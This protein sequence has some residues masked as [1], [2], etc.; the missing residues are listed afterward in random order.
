M[1]NTFALIIALLAVLA[2]SCSQDELLEKRRLSYIDDTEFFASFD[3]DSILSRTYI[4]ED[5]ETSKLYLRWTKADEITIFR[6]N[7]LNQRYQY[8][9]ETGDNSAGFRQIASDDFVSYN[10]LDNPTN[11]AVYPYNENTRITEKGVL[12]VALPANQKYA[13]KSFGL[14]ANTMVAVTQHTGDVNLLFKNVCGYFKFKFYGED[15]TIRSVTL[16]GNNEENLAGNANVTSGYGSLPAMTMVSDTTKTLTLDCGEAGI[17]VG[18]TKET[19]TEFWFVVPPTQFTK[20]FTITVTDTDGGKFTKTTEKVFEIKRNIVKPISA[21]EVE[22]V[23]DYSAMTVPDD[24]I[25]YIPTTKEGIKTNLDTS[26]KCNVNIVSHTY[27]NGKAIIKFDGPLLEIGSNN[28]GSYLA[29]GYVKEL[30]LPNC[31]ERI[32]YRALFG[33]WLKFDEYINY[34]N[35]DP[36]RRSITEFK[37]PDNL[38]EVDTNLF[39]ESRITK[40]IGK[41]VS[42][43]GRSLVVDGELIG[44]AAW[45]LEEYSVPENVSTING[46]IMEYSTVKKLVVPENVKT[47]RSG[48]INYCPYLKELYLPDELY[49]DEGGIDNCPALEE[50]HLPSNLTLARGYHFLYCDNIKNIYGENKYVTADNKCIIYPNYAYGL[51]YILMAAKNGLEEYSIPEGIGGLESYSFSNATSLRKLYF[52]ASLNRIGGD[53]FDGTY[54]VEEISGPNVRDDKRSLVVDGNLLYVAGGGLTTYTTPTDVTSIRTRSLS[55]MQEL[56]ELVIT[57]NVERFSDSYP[58]LFNHC[59]KL[60]TITISANIQHLGYDPFDCD[61]TDTPSLKTVYC[62]AYIPPKIKWNSF[63]VNTDFEDLTIYVPQETLS[64]YESSEDW[65]RLREYI[66]GYNYTDL[67][68]PDYYISTDYSQD[69][70]VTTLQTA[71]KGNGIDIVLMGDGYSDRQIADGTYD[72]TMNTAMEKF[73]SEE[74]YKNYRDHFNVYSVKAVSATEGY[75]CNNTA[76]SGYFGSGTRV[77]GDDKRVFTYAQKAI[78]E[79]R[80]D[81]ALI[82]VMMNST[83]YAGTCY[84]YHPSVTEGYGNGVSVSYFPVGEDENALAQVLHH[85]AGGHGFAKLADEYAY[86]S[87]GAIP[88]TEVTT[89]KEEQT[90]W[91]WWKNVDFTSDPSATRWSHFINDTRYANDGLGAYEGGLTYWT[92][93][94]RPT[95]NSIMRHNTGGFNAPS[96]EAIYYRIHKLAYGD[97]WQYDYEEFVKYDAINRKAAASSYNPYRQT[98]YKPLHAPVVIRKSWKDAQ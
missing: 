37:V 28:G 98:N 10:D 39:K 35:E 19:A 50:L 58:Y 48:A 79:E 85:E 6:G 73:F 77:G 30:Y 52:P 66:K 65:V 90:N 83:R 68:E 71:T 24:E 92:G 53:A 95:E 59:P 46:G 34:N 13:E 94:W 78:D 29:E 82:V 2:S 15:L 93:V 40:L 21:I 1:R 96:R 45:G 76:F 80:M 8:K 9:G 63:S 86:E 60:E 72:N 44:L 12:N 55:D 67:P 27:N 57:D 32:E 16:Q 91:G 81:E 61:E 31:V 36:V 69:G 3:T 22:T 87:M 47:I 75:E 62:R 11:Y 38:K 64:L 49:I 70:K 43:D 26:L 18:S 42:A 14:G 23:P 84:M 7:T 4:E 51:D 25:W 88:A 56:K 33:G 74:P 17:K 5:A 41:N 97:S 54:N 89:T 20:G